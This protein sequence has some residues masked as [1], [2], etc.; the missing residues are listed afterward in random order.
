MYLYFNFKCVSTKI[1]NKNAKLRQF[2]RIWQEKLLTLAERLLDFFFL[3][4]YK[5]VPQI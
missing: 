1:I 4:L 5:L 2:A 3:V